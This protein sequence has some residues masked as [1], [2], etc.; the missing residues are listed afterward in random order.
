LIAGP[1]T[2]RVALVHDWLTGMRGGERVL[3]ALLE[4]FPLAE[5]FTLIHR[6]GTVSPQ[7]EARTIHTSFVD[8]L[9]FAHDRYRYFLPLFPRAVESFDL[10]GFDLVISSSH[11]VAKGARPPLGVPH[12]CY[13][14]TPMR[15]V[16]DQYQAYFGRGRASPPVRVA[17]ATIAPWL[18]R[19]DVASTDRVDH[20]IANSTCVRDRI[21]RHYGRTSVVVYPPV[22][23][24]RFKSTVT[25]EDFY[26][27]LGALVPY[28][29]VDLAVEAFKKLGRR[30]VVAGVGPELPRLAKVAGPQ[31]SFLGAV[32]DAEVTDLLSRCRAFLLPGEED[33]GITA[34]EAQAAG[35]PVIAYGKG[36]ALE[37]V[38]GL[39]ANSVAQ[40]RSGEDAAQS[41]L[42]PTGVFFHEPSSTGLMAAIDRFESQ[43]F[44]VGALRASAARFGRQRF[45]QEI[46]SLIREVLA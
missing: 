36:G 26:L 43:D 7:I 15:Y 11:C 4:L 39:K 27:V 35:A 44:S 42:Q 21:R 16:W 37:T 28:K 13:C 17:I 33:F 18:R 38:I 9:P 5:I 10:D 30:L 45:E 40:Y 29:R 41:A 6:P 22:D 14:H 2:L 23:L 19:W 46:R 31:V 34:V 24:K 8:N 25:R 3:E 12:L 32:T 20:F 1:E